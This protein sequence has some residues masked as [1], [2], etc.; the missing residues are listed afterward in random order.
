MMIFISSLEMEAAQLEKRKRKKAGT[1]VTGLEKRR[2]PINRILFLKRFFRWEVL[3]ILTALICDGSSWGHQFVIDDWVYIVENHFIQN[4][5]NFLRILVSPLVPVHLYR[6]L[7]ALSLGVDCWVHGLNPDGFHVVN[8]LIHVMICLG[9]FW[10]LR[11]LLSNPAAAFLTALLFAAHPIQT[12]AVTY[13]DGRSDL[14]AMLFFVFAWLFHIHARHSAE[15]KR[16]YFA[17]ALVFYFFAMLSKESGITW[18]AVVLVTE[19]VYFSKS[20]PAALWQNLRK[21]LWKVFAGYLFAPLVFLALRAFAFGQV[22]RAHDSFVQNPLSHVPFLVRELTGLKVLFQ[23]LGL[24]FWPVHLSADYSYNQIPLI[25]QW[26]SPAALGC[27]ALSLAFL[28]LLG[29][30]YFRAPDVFFGLGYFLATYS[31]VSNLVIH[32]G[33][34]RADRLLYMPSLGIL[35]I[36]GI[37]LAG[38]DRR[39]Q[40]PMAKKALRLSLVVFVILLITRTVWRNSDWQDDRTLWLQTVQT[41][42]NSSNAHHALGSVFFARREY[43]LALEQYRVAE[44]IYAED[45]MLICD[46]G[47]VLS[48]VGRADEAMQY[49]RRA[50]DLDP[51]YPMLRFKLAVALRARGDFAGAKLQ[52]EAIIAF[53]DDLIRKNPSNAD[54][55]YFKAKALSA[56]GQLEQAL[57]E[58]RRTLQLDPNYDLAREG[59]DWITR[60]MAAPEGGDRIP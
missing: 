21:G 58:Y 47:D 60:K 19:F 30:S 44:T 51:L 27:I 31:V 54:H 40:W 56:Q 2:K 36:V 26:S 1:R 45:P 59:I 32:I 55:H 34:I 16:R 22:Q 24:L 5:R 11:H 7:T 4:P 39:L 14:L 41:A 42:P 9:T 12:E 20:S 49:Y 37:L 23:S 18:I 57:S 6:P 48:Q 53:Y 52:D 10:V 50:V 46:L 28:L 35:L 8:R 17:A 25:T 29:W 3:L 38:L 43:S 13:I 15:A 33:T